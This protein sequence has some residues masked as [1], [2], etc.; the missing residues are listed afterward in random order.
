MRQRAELQLLNVP[1][2]VIK[3]VPPEGLPFQDLHIGSEADDK[4][5]GAFQRVNHRPEEFGDYLGAPINLCNRCFGDT[6]LIFGQLSDET[7][8]HQFLCSLAIF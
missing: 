8:S 2:L 7:L 6:V 3:N 5:S 4:A 1:F